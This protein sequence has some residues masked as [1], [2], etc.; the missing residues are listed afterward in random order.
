MHLS[1]EIP[2]GGR[3]YK[4]GI[5]QGIKEYVA[6]LVCPRECLKNIC[7][8]PA[9]TANCKSMKGGFRSLCCYNKKS[10][11]LILRGNANI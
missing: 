6:G 2:L 1:P 3:I 7:L 10:N 5:K 11:N 8:P 4:S 9:Q